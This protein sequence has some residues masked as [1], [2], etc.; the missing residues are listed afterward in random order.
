MVIPNNRFHKFFVTI[1]IHEFFEGVVIDQIIFVGFKT[2]FLKQIKQYG[3]R[4]QL[5]ENLTTHA[6]ILYSISKNNQL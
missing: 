3:W 5:F 6:S 1:I 4:N 2:Y